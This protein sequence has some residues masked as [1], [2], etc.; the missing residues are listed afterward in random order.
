MTELP[1][2]LRTLARRSLLRRLVL[3]IA[4]VHA[5]MMTMFVGDLVLRQRATLAAEVADHGIGLA[6]LIA[7]NSVSWVLAD[8]VEGLAEVIGSIRGYPDVLYAMVVD[9][10]GRVVGHTDDSKLGLYVTDPVSLSLL[11]GPAEERFTVDTGLML[12]A[13]APIVSAGR[14]IGWARAGVTR[15]TLAL[16]LR[17]VMRDGVLYTVGAILAG[18]VF[19]WWMARRLTDDLRKLAELADHMRKGE[20]TIRR[21]H[22]PATEIATLEDAFV[23]MAETIWRRED[24]LRRSVD[25][26]TASNADL[27]QFAYV[28]SH[29]LQTPLREMTHYAQ[30][31]KRRYH[32]RLDGDADDFIDFIVNGGKRMTHLILDLLDYARVS[33]QGRALEAVSADEAMAAALENLGQ[34]LGEVGGEV[35]VGPLPTVLAD[36][37]QLTSLF[38]NLLGNAVKYRHPDRALRVTITASREPKDMWRFSVTD[39]GIGIEAQYFEKIFVIFQRLQPNGGAEGTGVGLAL[40]RRIVRRFGGTIWVESEPGVGSTF[41]FTLPAAAAAEPTP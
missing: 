6:R 36:D 10:H 12:E 26:L 32:G 29:D 27:E 5:V 38:Q 20:R 23:A 24:E 31:L 34:T 15:K 35:I 40:C 37:T 21:L 8:D 18:T 41:H 28:A 16:N 39:N 33:S 7:V 1:V 3:G 25:L 9:R 13:A 14:Q 22:L 4:A 11:S 19:A 2:V 30:L 17:G